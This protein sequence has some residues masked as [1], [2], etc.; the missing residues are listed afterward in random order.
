MPLENASKA[1]SLLAQ[2]LKE[3]LKDDSYWRE[4]DVVE[5]KLIRKTSR[6]VFFD[7]GQFGTGI[8]YGLELLNA[9]E[10]IKNLEPGQSCPQRSCDWTITMD[11]WSSP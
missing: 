8:V 10:L 7:I 6:Q 11:T 9:R 3:K 5:A 1:P 2:V 4:G